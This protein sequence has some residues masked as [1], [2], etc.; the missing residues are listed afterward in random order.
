MQLANA[1]SIGAYDASIIAGQKFQPAIETAGYW[2]RGNEAGSFRHAV[3]GVQVCL[4]AQSHAQRLFVQRRTAQKNACILPNNPVA[5][6]FQQIG[7][8]FIDYRNMRNAE[9]QHVIQHPHGIVALVHDERATAQKRTHHYLEAANVAHG[10]HHLPHTAAFQRQNAVCCGGGTGDAI[11][12][13]KRGLR[14]SRRARCEH[15]NARLLA[16]PCLLAFAGER[17]ELRGMR[18]RAF[19]QSGEIGKAVACRVDHQALNR[20]L[21]Q[22]VDTGFAR[23]VFQLHDAQLALFIGKTRIQQRQREAAVR[24][25][26]G[27]NHDLG[28]VV[29]IARKRGATTVAVLGKLLSQSRSSKASAAIAKRYRARILLHAEKHLTGLAVGHFRQLG[30]HCRHILYQGISDQ[31]NFGN[32]S[33][34]GLRFSLK[35][36]RPSFASS[37]V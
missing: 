16:I 1:V 27:K 30:N 23:G 4:C 2:S 7:Q 14:G 25:R 32:L 5:I 18:Y 8:D 11:P 10:Q 17:L 24:R 21:L 9:A 37:D 15:D 29:Q 31:G 3:A 12:R 35:A 26:Q 20:R 6:V 34:S 36:S 13:Q 28:T 19:R 33:K 22:Y